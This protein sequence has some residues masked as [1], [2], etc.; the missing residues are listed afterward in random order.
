VL[1]SRSSVVD[2]A[3]AVMFGALTRATVRSA[4]DA[5]GWVSGELAADRARLSSGD[6]VPGTTSAS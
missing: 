3:V 4:Y 1:A 5:A 6:L 2:E